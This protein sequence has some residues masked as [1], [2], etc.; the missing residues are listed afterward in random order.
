[1]RSYGSCSSGFGWWSLTSSQRP[2]I[3]LRLSPTTHCQTLLTNTICELKVRWPRL[4]IL[5]D[6]F[7]DVHQKTFNMPGGPSSSSFF[8]RRASNESAA[9]T[10]T[11][12]VNITSVLIYSALQMIG[13]VLHYWQYI[14]E[15]KRR[16]TVWLIISYGFAQSD[17]PPPLWVLCWVSQIQMSRDSSSRTINGSWAGLHSFLFVLINSSKACLV[18]LNKSLKCLWKETRVT[19]FWGYLW[20]KSEKWK[21]FN[22]FLKNSKKKIDLLDWCHFQ[23][24]LKTPFCVWSFRKSDF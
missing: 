10:D 15:S 1:M 16:K 6:H 13:D 23:T 14:L 21:H 24:N 11:A 5:S 8:P 7:T 2:H 22:F 20:S 3:N 18:P 12:Q 17:A 19:F 4:K 9:D